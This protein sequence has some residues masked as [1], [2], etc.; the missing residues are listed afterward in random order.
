CSRQTA[1]PPCGNRIADAGCGP[2]PADSTSG[3]RPLSRTDLLAQAWRPRES[4]DAY[5]ILLCAIAAAEA[6]RG[7]AFLWDKGRRSFAGSVTHRDRDQERALGPTRRH[8][9]DRWHQ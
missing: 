4:P 2:T 8:R 7:S 3:G 6:N 5:N 1:F 9:G